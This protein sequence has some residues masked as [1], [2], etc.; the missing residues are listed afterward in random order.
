[1]D[2][3]GGLGAFDI[4]TGAYLWSYQYL[5]INNNPIGLGIEGLTEYSD[6]NISLRFF[7]VDTL[8]KGHSGL[9]VLTSSG[10]I[11]NNIVLDNETDELNFLMEQSHGTDINNNT[12]VVGITRIA[13]T[14]DRNVRPFIA[15]FDSNL[16]LVWA[17]RLFAENFPYEGLKHRVFPN[18]DVIFVYNTDGD[19]PVIVGK[20]DTDGNLLWHRGY[21]FYNPEVQVGSDGSIYFLSPRR[22]FP[23]GTSEEATLLAKAD[24]NGDIES[25]P[26]FDA[27]LTLFDMDIPYTRWDWIR[28]S[29]DTFG[30]YTATITPFTTSTEDYCGTP[31]P[32]TPYFALPDTIC[33]NTSL[34]PDSL[35]NFLAHAVEWTITGQNT[36][37]EITDTTWQ[38]N[39]TEPGTY[40]IEQEIWLLGC[41]EFFTRNLTVLPDSLGNLLGE[42][43]LICEGDTLVL[44][45]RATRP[46]KSYEWQDGSTDSNI[47]VSNSGVF[48]VEVSDG[49]CSAGDQITLTAFEERY[50]GQII[51][52]PSDSSA[53]EDFLPVA[54]QPVSSFTDSFFLNNSNE[55]QSVFELNSAGN[56]VI[57]TNIE[58]CRVEENFELEITPCEVDIYIP[59]SFSPN[60]DGINDLIE[61]LGKDF[62]GL[63]LEVYNR[64]G[65]K[66]FEANTSPFAWDGNFNNQKANEGVYVLVFKYQNQRNG[67]E[68]MVSSDV[69]LVR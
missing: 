29:A 65:G 25:C 51:N 33:Q 36:N 1:M 57:S 38:Y 26:Q 2:S 16:D 41:S 63:S 6:G 31:A 20:L 21:S 50:P 68:E 3:P 54:L 11:I 44:S 9:A 52:L 4:A 34:G 14:T 13:L 18:G 62:S 23:D 55:A 48:S 60:S 22:Y 47:S 69:L 42:D 30:S 61:P 59:N 28:E 15:K 53:C 40:Q 32:P 67:S 45:P 49:F 43:E 24:P 19:L 5:P 8:Q 56:Y 7:T 39:F 35:Y 66:V 27:C 46:L 64:W 12:Y 17:K 10:E 58:N 37:L